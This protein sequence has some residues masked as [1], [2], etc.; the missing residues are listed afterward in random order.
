MQESMNK[1]EYD[2]FRIAILDFLDP[3]YGDGT[4]VDDF[5]P[6]CLKLVRE[7]IILSGRFCRRTINR[8][9]FRI[10][11]IFAWG[12][13]NDLVHESTWQALKVVKT[14]SKGH[15]GTF[16]HPEREDARIVKRNIVSR[17]S[18][19]YKKCRQ[20]LGQWCS[21]S[22]C[23]ECGQTKFL[24]CVLVMLTRHNRMDCG[25]ID[26]VHTKRPNTLAKS[27]F[28]WAGRSRNCL[29]RICLAKAQSRPSFRREQLKQSEM[30]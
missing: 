14:L 15:A 7:K 21:S 26:P 23:W 10:I 16:D 2:H 30:R 6:R 27:C 19:E 5:T 1:T 17:K 20:H 22:V 28:H 9:T 24:R 3:L 4:L 11:S 12:V 13:E 25:T 8:Y 29:L 18:I